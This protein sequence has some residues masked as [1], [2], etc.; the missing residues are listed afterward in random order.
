MN[1]D[2]KRRILTAQLARFRTW[3]YDELAAAIERTRREHG[4]LHYVDGVFDDGTEYHLEFNV[5]WDDKRG[6][7][8]RVCGD[9]TTAPRRPWLGLLPVLTPDVNDDFIMAR[10]GSFVGE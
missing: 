3:S 2:D 8:V 4:C 9:L 7:N 1:T 5:F 6:G 10:D